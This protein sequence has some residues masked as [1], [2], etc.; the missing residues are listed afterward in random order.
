[1]SHAA[2]T[3]NYLLALRAVALGRV[4]RT[5]NSLTY[6]LTGPCSSRLLWSLWRMH[7]IAE[8]PGRLLPGRHG[9][10]LTTKGAE[11]LRA[12]LGSDLQSLGSFPGLDRRLAKPVLR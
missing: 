12:A 4:F 11:T 9:M 8:P 1:M 2:L 10:I 3:D 7:L 5:Y 6:T